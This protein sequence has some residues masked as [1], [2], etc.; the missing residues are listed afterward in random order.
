MNQIHIIKAN[1]LKRT[2]GPRVAAGY[3]RNRGWS[4]EATLWIVCR[5]QSRI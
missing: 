2:L 3:L 1:F 4:M 5:V